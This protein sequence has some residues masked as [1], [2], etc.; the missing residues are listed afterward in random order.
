[1]QVSNVDGKQKTK[2][3][4]KKNG[5]LEFPKKARNSKRPLK[6]LPKQK[7]LDGQKDRI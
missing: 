1:M 5:R 6:E 3:Q 4:T 7:M 2:R